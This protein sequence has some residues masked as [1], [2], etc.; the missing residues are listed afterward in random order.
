LLLL[1]IALTLHASIFI[2]GQEVEATDSGILGF[3]LLNDFT[4]SPFWHWI[5][6]GGVVFFQAVFIN[7]LSIIHRLNNEVN[8]LPGLLWILWTALHPG[9]MGLQA[10]S[11]ALLFILP[12][13]SQ[14]MKCYKN[15]RSAIYLF[16]AGF[17]FSLSSLIFF[18]V[19]W[20]ALF[21]F[22]AML[23]MGSVRFPEPQQFLGGL[24]TPY[25]LA[26]FSV[27]FFENAQE[28]VLLQWE[29]QEIFG[30]FEDWD[31][32]RNE[33]ISGSIFVLFSLIALVNLQFYQA[34]KEIFAQRKVSLLFVYFLFGCLGT[35]FVSVFDLHYL[36]II[37][38]PLSILLTDNLYHMKNPL[39]AELFLWLLIAYSF[40]MQYQPLF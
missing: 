32:V 40:F 14:L 33:Y 36:L 10:N 25:V 7:R 4:P 24:I 22:L 35:L 29:Q 17:F 16:N 26:F 1:P 9:L 30:V 39:A 23:T 37:L 34:K 27:Y 20:L 2:Y 5:L 3:Y 13:M 11:L 21:G 15:R 12:G 19:S 28:F 18:P 31:L 38:W 8:I 6:A